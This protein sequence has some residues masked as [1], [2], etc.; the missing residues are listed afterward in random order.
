MG[1]IPDWVIWSDDAKKAGVLDD[2]EFEYPNSVL[3]A[4]PAFLGSWLPAG[5]EY[6]TVVWISQFFGFGSEFDATGEVA[7]QRIHQPPCSTE[8]DPYVCKKYMNKP[9]PVGI[10]RAAY[11]GVSGSTVWT[12]QLKPSLVVD[13]FFHELG[14]TVGL[15]HCNDDGLE[16]NL[17]HQ[18]PK[19]GLYLYAFQ[20]EAFKKGAR[21]GACDAL[22]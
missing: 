4:L 6:T 5:D 1:T 22:S 7:P 20:L 16:G 21:Y 9:A 15:C 8:Q 3:D 17:M 19:P 13:T 14:H 11:M 12:D 10:R 18:G 2:P